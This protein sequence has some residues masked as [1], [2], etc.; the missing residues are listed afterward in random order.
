MLKEAE[1]AKL[2]KSDLDLRNDFI[3]S[4]NAEFE[5]T[6]LD[7]R[8][9]IHFRLSTDK[10]ILRLFTPYQR[11][12]M[13]NGDFDFDKTA[14]ECRTPLTKRSDRLVSAGSELVS[15]KAELASAAAKL[16]AAES[17]IVKITK[18]KDE[19]ENLHNPG[20]EIPV[21]TDASAAAAAPLPAEPKPADIASP[22]MSAPAAVP[23]PAE[24]HD[25]P[26]I[27]FPQ[28]AEDDE[29]LLSPDEPTALRVAS[30]PKQSQIESKNDDEKPFPSTPVASK[31]QSSSSFFVKH[32][33]GSAALTGGLFILGTITLVAGIGAFFI[34]LSRYIFDKAAN[35]ATKSATLLGK[36]L[37][38][39][40]VREI[41]C[42]KNC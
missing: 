31:L 25:R 14:S 10:H 37:D 42:C 9:P 28:L 12:K 8:G 1:S 17:E 35:D 20:L 18:F 41:L 3:K 23:Y 27:L 36:D 34:A 38:A 5:N 4:L 39:I 13:M 19:V 21:K 29:V 26:V 30:V 15:A 22:V 33:A 24:S 7:K 6:P 16:A 40:A 2:S 11:H 32:Q